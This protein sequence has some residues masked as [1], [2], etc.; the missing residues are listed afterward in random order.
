[1]TSGI[2]NLF[3]QQYLSSGVQLHWWLT[4]ESR[5][6]LSMCWKLLLEVSTSTHGRDW[7]IYCSL[8]SSEQ[9]FCTIHDKNKCT[10]FRW[11]ES[12]DLCQKDCFYSWHRTGE[13]FLME[14]VRVPVHWNYALLYI[15]QGSA[16]VVNEHASNPWHIVV[17]WNL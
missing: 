8:T 9:Y 7:L 11:R 15:L 12:T 14:Q 13:I 4:L 16:L 2:F 5:E 1:M 6:K 10:S 17:L 3:I